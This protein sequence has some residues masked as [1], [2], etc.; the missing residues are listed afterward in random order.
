MLALVHD[1]GHVPALAND[2]VVAD[3]LRAVHEVLTA[4][5]VTG[6]RL[7]TMDV[8]TAA[9][10]Y[11]GGPELPDVPDSVPLRLHARTHPG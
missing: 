10:A 7:E 3:H 9:A 5:G 11:P 2:G 8:T 1:D 4:A 6:F